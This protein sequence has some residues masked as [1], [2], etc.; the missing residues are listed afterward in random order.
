MFHRLRLEY[1]EGLALLAE[2]GIQ[3]G[4]EDDLSTENE[5]VL[6][7]IVKEKVN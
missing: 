3:M 5:R 4:S 1:K 6:G 7:R 2:A